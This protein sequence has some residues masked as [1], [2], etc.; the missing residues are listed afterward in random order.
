V[1]DLALI[2]QI[3]LAPIAAA[4]PLVLLVMFLRGDEPSSL[5]NLWS[6]PD[7]EAWP[8]GVQEEEPMPW[9]TGA[10]S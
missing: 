4:A 7:Y 2:I 3:L 1:N 6:A 5:S 8:R 9:G 10:T